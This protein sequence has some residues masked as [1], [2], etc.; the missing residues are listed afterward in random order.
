MERRRI[1]RRKRR[2]ARDAGRDEPLRPGNSQVRDLRQLG[3]RDDAR[4]RVE[5]VAEHV[6]RR[7]QTLLPQPRGFRR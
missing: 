5:A 7:R 4:R 2:P 6:E 3:D 1:G